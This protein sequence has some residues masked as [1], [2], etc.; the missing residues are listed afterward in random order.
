MSLSTH[1]L[2]VCVCVCVGLIAVGGTVIGIIL[3]LESTAPKVS[4]GNKDG[5]RGSLKLL[6]LTV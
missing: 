6:Q 4:E 1:T 3:W 2:L 5:Q